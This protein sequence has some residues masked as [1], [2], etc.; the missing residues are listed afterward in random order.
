VSRSPGAMRPHLQAVLPLTLASLS[1]DPNYAED[2]D[3]DEDDADDDEDAVDECA[4]RRMS[5]LTDQAW[6]LHLSMMLSYYGAKTM[7]YTRITV[8]VFRA[9]C[10]CPIQHG[11]RALLRSPSSRAV[12]LGAQV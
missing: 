10:L 12:G 9:A 1:F 7:L 4:P 2:M 3:A 8:R 6:K 11:D 5:V